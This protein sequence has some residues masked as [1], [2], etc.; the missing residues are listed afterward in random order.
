MDFITVQKYA[1]LLARPFAE[2]IFKLLVNYKNI[3]ASEAA[4]RLD[5]HI[6]TAQDFLDELTALGI[7]RKKEVYEKKR[8]YFRYE[9]E[10]Y[11]FSINVDLSQFTDATSGT[12]ERLLRR[13]RERKNAN[14]V[15]TVARTGEFLSSVTV[16]IGSGR[17]KKER[18][19]SLT[20][21]QGKFLY[22]L[23]F[24][25]AQPQPIKEIIAQ[26]GVAAQQSEV[27]DIVE[28][29]VGYEVIER[30]DQN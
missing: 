13:I 1:S 28:L 22:H 26:A 27:L 16:I 5:L 29:L 6:K 20:Q 23:P 7:A 4:T 3:S 30:N 11:Q 17:E 2:N 14:A 25:T 21:A 19:I 10:K 12:D 8:P 18:K 15:F 24:P 9:L